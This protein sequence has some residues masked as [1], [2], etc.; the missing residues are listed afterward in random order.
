MLVRGYNIPVLSNATGG[1]GQVASADSTDGQVI[2]T[3]VGTMPGYLA[4]GV[5][6]SV[7]ANSAV[8]VDL[9]IPVLP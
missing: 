7:V 4:L 5:E 9:D 2:G 6:R 8:N 1:I 3:A